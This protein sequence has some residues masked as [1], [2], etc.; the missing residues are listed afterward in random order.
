MSKE[1]GFQVPIVKNKDFYNKVSHFFNIYNGKYY[2]DFAGMID[3][4]VYGKALYGLYDDKGKW[5]GADIIEKEALNEVKYFTTIAI[6]VFM[7]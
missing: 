4:E 2:F 1:K 6:E 5:I 7:P 3:K